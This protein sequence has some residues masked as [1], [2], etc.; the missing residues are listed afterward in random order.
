MTEA[1]LSAQALA[2]TTG[3]NASIE[4]VPRFPFPVPGS[5]LS[6]LTTRTDKY[7]TGNFQV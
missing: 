4:K 1:S 6:L 2:M 5:A 7:K 3:S